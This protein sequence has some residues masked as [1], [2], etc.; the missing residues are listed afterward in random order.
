MCD[1]MAHRAGAEHGYPSNLHRERFYRRKGPGYRRRYNGGLKALAAAVLLSAALTVAIAWPVLAS[2]RERIFGRDAAGRHHDPFTV[3]WQFANERPR[4]PY[5]QPLVDDTG[6]LAS[7]AV[8][9]VAAYNLI[10][11]LSFPLTALATFLFARYLRMPPGAAAA[12]AIAFAFAP[13]HLAH[14]AYHPHV[15]QTQWLPLYFLALWA[16]VDRTTPARAAGF[17]LAAA[18]VLLSN[19]YGALMAAV[20]TPVVVAGIWIARRPGARRAAAGVAGAAAALVCGV[21]MARVILPRV[22]PDLWRFASDPADLLRY[23]ARWWGYFVPPVEHPLWGGAAAGV[24]NGVV[25]PSAIVE[26]QISISYALM[27]FAA[28]AI[29]TRARARGATSVDAP[30][31]VHAVPVLA[32]LAIWAAL[33]SLAPTFPLAP[34]GWLYE[35]VPMFRAYARFALLTHLAVALL[36]GIGLAIVW[37]RQRGAAVALLAVAAIEYAPL[38]ARSRDVLP[39]AG[40]RWIASQP[41]GRALDCVQPSQEEALVSWL[42]GKDLGTL[43]P[44]LPSCTELNIAQ[45]A[46]TLGYTHII[47]RTASG[48]PGIV[49][50]SRPGLARAA[51]FED[52]AVYEV[53]GDAAPVTVIEMRGF[54]AVEGDARESWRWM[55]QQGE[56][57]VSNPRISPVRV[58]LEMEL[59]ALERPRRIAV[60]VDDV[61]VGVLAAG[62]APGRHHAGPMTLAPGVHRVTFIALEPASRGPGP[63]G[64]MLTVRL[65]DWRWWE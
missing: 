6:A 41:H 1:P 19:A 13:P 50:P 7:R 10:V 22:M 9:P 23:G 25:M 42:M 32:A 63:D 8:G 51:T 37:K 53:V 43:S 48:A 24:W 20:T 30:A 29:W 21:A 56:W 45:Q 58:R 11:L 15:A 59:A 2:P 65:T 52:A 47:S 60:A 55:G 17:A 3:M 28:V 18:A 33:C 4:F 44:A 14:A 64:R 54:S 61:Q 16:C 38:P 31:S 62:A 49:L 40:H 35:A 5:R 26:H 57:I 34:A 36:A 39:T 12:A 27:A 46:A